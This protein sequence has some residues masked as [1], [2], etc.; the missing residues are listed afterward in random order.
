M[1]HTKHTPLRTGNGGN[2]ILSKEGEVLF[3]IKYY[4]FAAYI[5]KAVNCHAELLEALEFVLN[6][7]NAN[8]CPSIPDGAYVRGKI[9]NAIAKA[10]GK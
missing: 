7:L 2:M 3:F 9:V 10:K 4:D 1:T 6:A 8:D 5:V